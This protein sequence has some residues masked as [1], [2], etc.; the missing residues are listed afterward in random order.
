MT[1]L[2]FNRHLV[3]SPG[4]EW[5]GREAEEKNKGLYVFTNPFVYMAFSNIHLTLSVASDEVDN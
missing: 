4:L 5:P 2:L 1:S 3:P